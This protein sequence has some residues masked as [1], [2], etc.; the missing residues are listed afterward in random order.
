MHGNFNLVLHPSTSDQVPLPQRFSL[1]SDLYSMASSSN[2]VLNLSNS[3]LLGR[4]LSLERN[5]GDEAG[6]SEDPGK[7]PFDLEKATEQHAAWLRSRELC[8]KCKLSFQHLDVR[9]HWKSQVLNLR[10]HSLVGLQKSAQRCPTCQLLLDSLDKT[11]LNLTLLDN[12]VENAVGA[13]TVYSL[14]GS[15]SGLYEVSSEFGTSEKA[16]KIRAEFAC[17]LSGNIDVP[18]QRL[19]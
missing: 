13:I 14:Y 19:N 8:S 9:G 10:H 11:V 1:A 2:K 3:K 17:L 7:T 12:Q 18:E 5:S 16:S 15:Q 4:S 6:P